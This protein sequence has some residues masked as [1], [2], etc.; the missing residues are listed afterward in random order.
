[1]SKS[2]K[3][4]RK[5]LIRQKIFVK[6]VLGILHRPAY[7]KLNVST[8]YYTPKHDTFI[9]ISNHTDAL[10]PGILIC[11]L[12][13]KYVRFVAS[14]HVTRGGLLGWIIKNFTGV[15]VKRR[16]NPSEVLINDILDTVKAGVPVGIFAEGSTSFNGETG[17]IS[18]NTGKMVKDSGVALITFRLVGGYLRSSRWTQ[19]NKVGPVFGK[20][21][22]EYSPEELAKMSVDEVNEIIRRDTYVN[23]FEE[24]RKNPHEYTGENLAEHL[25]RIVFVCPK[26]KSIGHLHSKGDNLKCDECGYNVNY[27]TDAFF[28]SDENEVIFDNVLEW[29]KWQKNIWKEKVISAKDG[30]LIYEDKGQIVREIQ[31]DN[32]IPVSDNANVKI[33]KDKFVVELSDSETVEMP[34]EKIKRVWV[35]AKDSFILVDDNHYFDI[36]THI[37]RAAIKYVAAWRYLRGKDFY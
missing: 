22:N 23:A 3:E 35:A 24:Q 8:E 7:K 6:T 28:H 20:V 32:K 27:G 33:Y 19:Q 31:E 18:P 36:S 15:I 17:Y 37:P 14:D 4:V 10:D 2:R 1:M 21:V 9:L 25:E 30:E 29:D 13:N 11:A 34:I 16:N 5:G 26:C 12:K